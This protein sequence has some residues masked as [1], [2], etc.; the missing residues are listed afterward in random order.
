MYNTMAKRLTA[1]DYKNN[2]LDLKD[3]LVV[4]EKRIEIRFIT[5]CRQYPDVALY[6]TLDNTQVTYAKDYDARGNAHGNHLNS[7]LT[8]EERICYIGVIEKFL[9]DKHPH[10][11][12]AIDFTQ[13]GKTLCPQ[14]GYEVI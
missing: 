6:N 12:T 7:I 8:T 14:C 10:K 11:Q 13:E 4:L 3:S 9:E 2:Y 1:K 5:L